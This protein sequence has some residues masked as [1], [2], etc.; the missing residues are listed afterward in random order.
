M[1]SWPASLPQTVLASATRTRQAGKI[2]SGMDTGAPKQRQRFTATVKNY[3]VEIIV[4]GAQLATFDTFYKTTI[5]NGTDSFTW[6]DP[7][8]GASATLRFRE[9]P[10]E[11]VIKPDS[12]A[13][14]RLFKISLPLEELP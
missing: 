9:E 7:F 6:T 13:N 11:T 5:N 3:D 1:T 4:T 2:R 8:T 12:T 14:N 10:S